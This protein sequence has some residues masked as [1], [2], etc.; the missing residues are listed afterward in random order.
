MAK[1]ARKGETKQ[2]RDGDGSGRMRCS[3]CGRVDGVGENEAKKDSML[4]CRWRTGRAGL[5]LSSDAGSV[6]AGLLVVS[7]RRSFF[8]RGRVK[9]VGALDCSC[10]VLVQFAWA[11][12][13]SVWFRPASCLYGLEA[14]PRC[15]KGPTTT[16]GS[17]KRK[18]TL[19]LRVLVILVLS[20]C[21]APGRL[22]IRL[23]S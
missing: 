15:R 5:C 1:R 23:T 14:V 22:A 12:P 21:V 19:P 6:L 20:G 2:P 11:C 18:G 8:S 7:L 16:G 3:R 17:L 10:P 4:D 13:V 9:R